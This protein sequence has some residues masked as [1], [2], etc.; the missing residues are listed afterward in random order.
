MRYSMGKIG[1]IYVIWG[2]SKMIVEMFDGPDACWECEKVW[3]SELTRLE[4]V[5]YS[6]GT[7]DDYATK[8]L[9]T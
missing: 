8:S 5:K 3:N 4:R 7:L 9:L 2:P 1:E 6:M